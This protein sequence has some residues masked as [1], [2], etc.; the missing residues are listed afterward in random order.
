MFSGDINCFFSCVYDSR[1]KSVKP[2][3]KSYREF[4]FLCVKLSEFLCE[5]FSFPGH[6]SLFI[7]ENKW[8]SMCVTQSETT[9]SRK[10]IQEP[11]FRE[12]ES[13]TEVL[14]L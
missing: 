10:N 14:F 8:F 2:S 13:G 5:W 3:E 9:S 4:L 1:T 11:F 7:Y 12:T 6:I